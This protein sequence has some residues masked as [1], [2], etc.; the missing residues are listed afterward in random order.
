M[1]GRAFHLDTWNVLWRNLN[2]DDLFVKWLGYG[3]DG[4]KSVPGWNGERSLFCVN[5][6][7]VNH[8]LPCPSGIRIIFRRSVRRPGRDVDHSYP[9]SLRIRGTLSVPF[10]VGRY[11]DQYISGLSYYFRNPVF[12]RWLPYE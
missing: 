10:S 11:R 8:H 12:C 4:S 2:G 6:C 9:I 3:P 1:L 5:S 7:S